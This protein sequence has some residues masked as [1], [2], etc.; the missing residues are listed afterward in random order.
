MGTQ[1]RTIPPHKEEKSGE[2]K[3]LKNVIKRLERENRQLKSELNT[4]EAYFKKTQNFVK[5]YTDDLTAQE[6]INGART[7]KKL[8]EI[9]EVKESEAICSKCGS[10][11]VV[12]S[13]LPFGE[14]FSCKMENCKHVQVKKNT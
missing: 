7:G 10:D 14:M 5:G 9:I 1:R 12:I 13:P 8:K 3:R 4:M 2:E 11:N 6:L